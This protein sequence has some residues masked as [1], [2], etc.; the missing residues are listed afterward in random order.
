[1]NTASKVDYDVVILTTCVDRPELH[2]KIFLDYVRYIG[3]CN[4]RWII[5][6]N[7]I[8]NRVEETEKNLR[9]ILTG[10]DVHI[11][12]YDVG[13]NRSAWYESVKYCINYAYDINPKLGYFW[14]EDDWTLTS[15]TLLEDIKLLNRHNHH[16]SL[17]NRNEVSFNPGLWDLYSYEQLMYKSINNPSECIGK[18]YVDGLNTN[19]ERICCPHPEST[20]FVDNFSS[21]ARFKD[22]GREWQ[23]HIDNKRTFQVN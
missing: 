2:T 9:T 11:K 23:H 8:S 4:V 10:Y 18:R 20:K 22:A 15:G 21:V 16:V 19:P 5:T 14:L 3:D 13:G 17:A 6:I 1:M 7:N 12:T